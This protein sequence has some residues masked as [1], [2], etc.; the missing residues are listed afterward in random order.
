MTSSDGKFK[1]VR[2]SLLDPNFHQEVFTKLKKIENVRKDNKVN[3]HVFMF[4]FRTGEKAARHF[5]VKSRSKENMY[6]V[7]YLLRMV[8]TKKIDRQ[9]SLFDKKTFTVEQFVAY[10]CLC[11]TLDYIEF[12]SLTINLRNYQVVGQCL[13]DVFKT[14][15]MIND[16]QITFKESHTGSCTYG[17]VTIYN[18]DIS[19]VDARYVYSVEDIKDLFKQIVEIKKSEPKETFLR[20]VLRI[21]G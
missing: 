20:K 18:C 3:E 13:N 8:C 12:S 2:K 19:D 1:S 7:S 14:F 17:Y 6:V 11:Q 15:E 21:F 5:F 4:Y 9:K 16:D 10:C